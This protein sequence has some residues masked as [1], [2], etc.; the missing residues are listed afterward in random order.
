MRLGRRAIALGALVALGV[1]PAA[2]NAVDGAIYAYG[3]SVWA[4]RPGVAASIHAGPVWLVQV[5]ALNPAGTGNYW[6]MNWGCPVPGSEVAAVQFGALRTQ[7]ASSLA[8]AVTGDR[9][10][11]WAEGDAGMP[12]SPAG[13]RVY[14]IALP[15]GQC[16]VHLALVQVE[17]RAQHA[18]GYFIDSP[19]ILV[20]DVA[21]PAAAMRHVPP[22]W[23]GAGSNAARVGWAAADNFGSDGVALQRISVAGHVRWSGAPG[24]GE[25]AVDVPLDGF[26]DGVHQVV[27]QVDG[28]GTAGAS[29]AG[30]IHLDRTPPAAAG[31]AAA[32]TPEGGAALRWTV[33]DNLSGASGSEAQVNAAG[34]GSSAGAWEPL[35]SGSGPGPH[36]AT[37]PV[38]VADGVH[39]WRVVATDGAGNVGTTPAPDR[40]VVD[41]TP[42]SLELHG[43]PGGWVRDLEL[44]L[45]AT[46]NLQGALGLGATQ[47]DVNAAVGGEGGP[48]LTRSSAVAP[49]GRRVVPIDLAGLPDGRHLV[50]VIVRNGGAF[51]ERLT[52]ERRATIRVDRTPPAIGRATFT[53]GA[54]TVTAAWSA[55]DELAGVEAATVQWRDGA[56]WRTLASQQASDGARSMAIDASALPLGEHAFRVVVADAAGNV[57]A[58]QG[59][60]RLSRG[61]A[62][63]TAADPFARLRSSRLS[64]TVAKARFARVGGRRVLLRRIAI[65]GTVTV[66]G[67]LRDARGAAIAGAEIRARGHRGVIAGRALTRRD[68]RF[69][70]VARPVAGGPLRIG[71]P[72]GRELL[73]SRGAPAVVVEVRPRVSLSASSRVATAGQEVL[74]SGRLFPSPGAIGLGSRKGVVLEWR[75]PVRGTWRPVVNA[76][77]RRDGT[78][79]IPWSFALRGLSIP[80]RVSVPTEVGWPLL[81][82]RSGVIA[83]AVR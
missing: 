19:R 40:I 9:Q 38:G 18:R 27:V 31:L 17:A 5:P 77:I 6:E 2:A 52:A 75:D 79:A 66:S 65:G 12:Q 51:G 24:V 11:L 26:G 41:T 71:V 4:A 60:A 25:H 67:R 53:P 23:I 33:G 15:G 44:D 37:V 39:A 70:L 62:G 49:P 59:E 83:V 73:P 81:P 74:F 48:W 28:D 64:L 3:S 7:V 76:R 13:G 58:R 54:G 55:D 30:V 63:S 35:A 80:M 36:G 42:P 72:A 46:D 8:V 29:A 61:G 22:G 45:S 43:V 82:A 47:V 10:V 68:G 32:A 34:D 56:A 57:A 50:R 78:F 20:R 14:H 16:N 69:R 1:A 21:P